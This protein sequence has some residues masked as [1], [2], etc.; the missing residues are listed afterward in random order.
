MLC[1]AYAQPRPNDPCL[2]VGQGN[3]A[4][5]LGA[6]TFPVP[7]VQTPTKPP[8]VL[9]P[10]PTPVPVGGTSLF[11]AVDAMSTGGQFGRR[12]LLYQGRW[13]Y[14]SDAQALIVYNGAVTQTL[15]GTRVDSA[16]IYLHR[17]AGGNYA[18]V[19]AQLHTATD[20]T[21]TGDVVHGPVPANNVPMTIGQ[22]GWFP[23]DTNAAQRLVDGT[24]HSVAL[25]GSGQSQYFV[26]SGLTR[27]GA[28]GQLSITWHR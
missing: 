2:C 23:F 15:R 4:W 18:P 6:L 24:A 20:I 7:V 22:A 26:G 9:P 3:R 14:G 11:G 13:S 16:A 8:D 25:I 28:M 17:E 21:M 19:S 1:S 12:D 10:T 27:D 5:V